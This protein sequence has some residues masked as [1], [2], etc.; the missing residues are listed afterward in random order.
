MFRRAPLD[1][2]SLASA[3]ALDEKLIRDLKAVGIHDLRELRAIGTEGAWERLYL[4][5]LRDTLRDALAIEGA[6]RGVRKAYMDP[7]A[8]ERLANYIRR[9][10][11]PEVRR[12]DER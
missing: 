4:A 7:A 12:H 6:V 10:T 11:S 9:R 3:R 8:R 1:P 5:D 2:D